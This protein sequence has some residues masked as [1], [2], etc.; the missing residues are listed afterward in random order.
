MEVEGKRI[1]I[2]PINVARTGKKIEKTNAGSSGS[3]Y[4]HTFSWGTFLTRLVHNFMKRKP[5]DF[6]NAHVLYSTGNELV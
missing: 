5:G 4:V 3:I 2:R 6:C 1:R